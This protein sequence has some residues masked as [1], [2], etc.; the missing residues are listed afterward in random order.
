DGHVIINDVTDRDAPRDLLFS[1]HFTCPYCAISL[2]EIEPRT[3]SFNSP[4]GAC[5]DCQGLGMRL[6]VDA[7]LVIPNQELSLIDGAIVPW[8]SSGERD[9]NYYWQLLQCTAKHFDISLDTPLRELTPAQRQ[10]ILHGS[11]DERIAVSYRNRQGEQR[12]YETTYE[13]V[14]PNLQRRYHETTSDYARNK[15]ASYMTQR[16]C[17]TCG[18]ARLRP[19]SLGVTIAEQTINDVTTLPVLR[20]LEWIEELQEGGTSPPLLGQRQRLI[21]QQVLKEIHARLQFMVNVGLDYL[22]LNRTAGTLSGG[23]AQRIRLATQ[24]GSQL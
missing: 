7:D 1:E 10:L 16:P 12:Q 4:H 21:A 18:G 11:G 24:I 2:P 13:G 8:D 19:E 5:P 3:F 14:V 6:K 22:T 23:E 17:P 20:A 9:E 15:I